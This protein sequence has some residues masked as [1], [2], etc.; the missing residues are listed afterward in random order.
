MTS[1]SVHLFTKDTHMISIVNYNCMQYR[2]I[3][4]YFWKGR[5]YMVN[6]FF[7]LVFFLSIFLCCINSFAVSTIGDNKYHGAN[8]EFNGHLCDRCNLHF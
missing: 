3:K 2:P 8:G 6:L 1:R 7:N 4:V 5:M